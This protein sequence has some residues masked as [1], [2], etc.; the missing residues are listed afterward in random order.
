M[1]TGDRLDG[2]S[3][4]VT[5]AARGIGYSI[6]RKL[7][8]EGADVVLCDRDEEALEESAAELESEGL[9]T[10]AVSCD[11]TDRD[12]TR[13]LVEETVEAFGSVDVLVNNAGVS[14]HGS[15]TE[16][17][18][19][20]W[21][22]VIDVNLTGVFNCSHAALDELIDGGGSIVNISSMAG[23]NISYH[24]AAN[25]T[26]S[27]WG[28]IG[29]TKHLAWDLGE[30]DVRVNAVCPGSTLTPMI[31]AGTTPAERAETEEKIP[32]DRWARPEDQA[33]AVAYLVSEEGSYLTGTV[34]EVDGGKQLGV[35]HEI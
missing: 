31:E 14:T 10:A 1:S 25:Y 3:A 33:G 30:H 21:E 26:A 2:R 27:K 18:P 15:F 8:S 12:Q 20:Q 35:R 6:A 9:S 29:F 5:G 22:E 13:A 19:E 7:G 16:L 34:V 23:R 11:V 17:T 32:L 24:A 4:I 28:V